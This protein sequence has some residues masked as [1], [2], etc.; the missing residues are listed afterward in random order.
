MGRVQDF[1]KP[2][3]PAVAWP[4]SQDYNEAIQDPGLCF[5]DPE[6]RAGEAVTN[7][8]GLPMPRSGTFA[9]VYE[10]RA[11]ASRWAVKCF[12]RAAPAQRERYAAI[13]AYLRQARLPFTVDFDYLEQ[14]IRVGGRW[15]P[16][17]K[18]DWV[19]GL[20]LNEFV[21]QNL[22]RPA[23]LEALA[24]LWGR[25]ARRLRGAGLAHGDLQHGNV[26]LVPGRDEKH[27][28]VKL[29]DYDG[30][31]VPALAQVPSGEVGH[32]AFQHPQ[33]LREATYSAEVDRFPLLAVACALR[34]LTVGG[35][36]LWE[37]YDNGDNLLFCAAD[38]QK[39]A[40]SRLLKSLWAFPDPAL[41]DLTGRLTLALLGPLNQVPVLDE[42][43]ADPHRLALA[44]REEQQVTAVL[45]RGAQVRGVL[46]A[47][48]V[49]QPAR[50]E[51][52]PAVPR[53]RPTVLL[54]VGGILAALSVAGLGACLVGALLYSQ[55][56][57]SPPPVVAAG[58]AVPPAAKAKDNHPAPPAKLPPEKSGPAPDPK[59]AEV[60]LP[61]KFTNGLGMEFVLVPVGGS[62][63]GGSG[64]KPGFREV[65]IPRDF[66]LGVYEV[67]QEE[68]QKVMGDNPS[69]FSRTGKGKDA[70]QGVPDDELKR[71]PVESVSWEDAQR[72]LAE[73]NKRDK[74][75]GWVYRLP[76][77]AEWEYACR[78]GPLNDKQ[79]SA[80]DYYLDSPTNL[81]LP[82]HANF[83]HGKG[84]KRTCKVGSYRPNRMGLCDMHGNVWEWCADTL[85]DTNN[86][87]HLA[88]GDSQRVERGGCWH[89]TLSPSFC[90]ASARISFPASYRSNDHGLRVARVPAGKQS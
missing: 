16:A 21:R 11:P 57:R 12:T 76:T 90:C 84:L 59:I 80:F 5:A 28:A 30:M 88:K 60:K 9:D 4:L 24:E 71:F 72:F 20:L 22:D 78:G 58:N 70:V 81:L 1:Y 79:D 85:V 77:E 64:G 56:L 15:Y 51:G 41:H 37:K 69:H 44:P 87:L 2:G 31:F 48:V 43:T 54:T 34:A 89:D 38:F 67:M 42:L 14:G 55:A 61:A 19:E 65:E 86:L 23:M 32:P 13:S 74:V 8:L 18:M 75:D 7:A 47:Y 63:L 10:V 73:I 17:L 68:W 83:E 45:G 49:A 6:L 62:W 35:R 50:R 53:S 82:E 3:T 39:P 33:R 52:E 25:L 29:I 66:Y 27:L 26:L 40:E 46:T 36:P